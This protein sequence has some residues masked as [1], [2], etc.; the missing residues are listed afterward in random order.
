MDL[1]STKMLD[2]HPPT[3]E[4]IARIIATSRLMMPDSEISLGCARPRK[5]QPQ[6]DVLAIEAGVNR[7]AIP[8]EQ[9]LERAKEL[10]LEIQM[11]KTCC[12]L[13]F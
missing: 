7:M 11:E 5:Q 9:G 4:E 2:V 10:G 3:P 8:T 12:S 1:D 6:I 13:H